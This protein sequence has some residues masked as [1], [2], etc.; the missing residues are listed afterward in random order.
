MKVVD[1]KCQAT[2]IVVNTNTP[3]TLLTHTLVKWTT[4]LVMLERRTISL[5][6]SNECL[7]TLSFIQVVKLFILYHVVSGRIQLD[8]RVYSDYIQHKNLIWNLVKEI[9]FREGVYGLKL[10]SVSRRVNGPLFSGS[11][12]REPDP[13]ALILPR[14][15]LLSSLPTCNKVTHVHITYSLI[16][17][18]CL[19]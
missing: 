15:T 2:R 6:V 1:H 19:L 7:K 4:V 9:P 12:T 17:I 5:I 13:E 14:E 3:S 10:G 8:S 11:R 16:S 18:L